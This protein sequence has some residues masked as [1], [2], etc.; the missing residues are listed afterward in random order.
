M[1]K[2][3]L[4][5][6]QP[7]EVWR[8]LSSRVTELRTMTAELLCYI[9]EADARQLYRDQACDSMYAC[10]VRVLLMS[11]DAACRR[12]DAARVARRFPR[13]FPALEDG[14]LNVSAI[15]LLKPHLTTSNA[16]ELISAAEGKS[17]RA[18]KEFLACR[19]PQADLPTVLRRIGGSGA[20]AEPAASLLTQD[21]AS[22]LSSGVP[23]AESASQSRASDSVAVAP[24]ENTSQSLSAAPRIPMTTAQHP[25]LSST[26]W[27]PLTE[28]RPRIAPLSAERYGLQVTISKHA[29]DLLRRAQDL[30]AHTM[31]SGDVGTVLERALT[32]LVEKLE[33]AKFAQ[34]AHPRRRR[35]SGETRHIP[36]EI[37][38]QVHER[39]GG[40]CTFMSD[41]GRRCESRR[42]L[43][44]DHIQPLAKGGRTTVA[45]VRQLCA[46]HNQLE[47]ERR[48]GAGFMAEKREASRELAAGARAS[49][50]MFPPESSGDTSHSTTS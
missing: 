29:H 35:N 3:W 37:K 15:L 10:C 41:E 33:H 40:R 43:E 45:N 11:E 17:Y 8:G 30:L 36:A 44:Y 7:H 42:R 24:S 2:Y 12:I 49:R 46:K 50:R 39:D 28:P 34:T 32:E 25:A 5:S 18:I 27:A 47:A 19:F 1:N 26:P 14:R 20:E 13:I 21:A 4:S 22:I 48:L 31:P 38:R 16:D 9:A 23:I 6:L